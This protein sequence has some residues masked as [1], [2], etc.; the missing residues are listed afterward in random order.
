MLGRPTPG[1]RPLVGPTYP[2]PAASL[3]HGEPPTRA[4]RAHPD[5]QQPAARCKQDGEER[6]AL[7]GGLVRPRW[8]SSCLGHRALREARRLRRP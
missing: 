6:T 1:P 3:H 8:L 2:G 7:Q 4:A 5:C